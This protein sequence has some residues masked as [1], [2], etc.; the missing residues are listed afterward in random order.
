MTRSTTFVEPRDPPSGEAESIAIF[1]SA[2]WLAEDAQWLGPMSLRLMQKK[3]HRLGESLNSIDRYL[4]EALA[5]VYRSPPAQGSRDRAMLALLAHFCEAAGAD[6]LNGWIGVQVETGRAPQ[7][8]FDFDEWKSLADEM[9]RDRPHAKGVDF[10][11]TIRMHG[12]PGKYG[13]RSELAGE[14]I[15]FAEHRHS[16]YYEWPQLVRLMDVLVQCANLDLSRVVDIEAMIEHGR[17]AIPDYEGAPRVPSSENLHLQ[18][19]LAP[20]DLSTW[21]FG[22]DA[23]A[24]GCLFPSFEACPIESKGALALGI[25]NAI[26]RWLAWKTGHETYLYA[27]GWELGDHA[28]PY[29][30]GLER[31]AGLA[32]RSNDLRLRR[33]WLWFAWCTYDTERNKTPL[34]GRE[35]ALR[36]ATEDIGRLRKL[37][38][39][40]TP[41]PAL[42]SPADAPAS[43]LDGPRESWEEFEWE[44]DH[45]STCMMLLHRHGGPW[46]GM[47]PMLLAIR[48]LTAASVATDLRYWN[49]SG[50]EEQIPEPWSAIT[51]W[52]INMFQNLIGD[53]GD[54]GLVKFRGELGEFLL[55]RLVD[56]WGQAEREDAKRTGRRRTDDDMVERSWKWRYCLVRA[57]SALGVNPGSRGHRTLHASSEMDPSRDVREAARDAYERVR[58]G[59]GLPPDVSPRR[60]VMTALWWYRQG[61]LLGLGIQPDDDGAQRTRQ[62]ELTRTKEMERPDR[63]A[64]RETES[65]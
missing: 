56:R 22:L 47:K 63:S 32:E 23:R 48:S 8:H 52:T 49:E 14:V 37:L 62:K 33:A 60:A 58:R 4:L 61:H 2:G 44:K 5:D 65:Q 3:R 41:K 64:T 6:G 30:D 38:A 39:R 54:E 18:P 25:R 59:V 26:E 34:E 15:H 7:F 50:L 16:R 28:R 11:T 51:T 29:L 24:L 36:A 45:L 43:R 17:A 21:L 13:G 57:F 46:R 10:E 9:R 31:C 40:A 20:T 27:A 12:W 1:A 55:E 42:A 53:Y 19:A 35:K